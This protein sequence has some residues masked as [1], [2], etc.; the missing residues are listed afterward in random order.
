MAS[1]KKK[2]IDKEKYEEP[3]KKDKKTDPKKVKEH[4]AKAVDAPAKKNDRD[5]KRD[6]ERREPPRSSKLIHQFLPFIFF[7]I[8]ILIATCL[9]AVELFHAEMGIAGELISKIFC[10]LFGWGSFTIPVMIFYIGIMWH[11][12]IDEGNAKAKAIIAT[13]AMLLFSVFI[14]IFFTSES[15]NFNI[16]DLWNYGVALRGCGVIGGLICEGLV[17]LFDQVGTSIIAMASLAIA[18]M[19]LFNLTPKNIW[20]YIRYKRKLGRERRRERAAEER[21]RREEE[22]ERM[23]R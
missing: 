19:F 11:K 6:D 20:T 9:I 3:S 8:A 2:Q 13:I 4:D 21:E 17:V 12:V 14:H 1:D 7:A 18:L 22:R 5:H 15:P 23:E 10:G 16:V